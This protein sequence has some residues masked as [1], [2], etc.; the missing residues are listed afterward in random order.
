MALTNLCGFQCFGPKGAEKKKSIAGVCI[1]L[2]DVG[3]VK[4]KCSRRYLNVDEMIQEC[5]VNKKT[6]YPCTYFPK[7]I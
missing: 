6:A 3:N 4:V 7:E 1:V 5:N 2:D